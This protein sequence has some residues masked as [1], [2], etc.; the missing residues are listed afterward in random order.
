MEKC[1]IWTF[2]AVMNDIMNDINDKRKSLLHEK[3]W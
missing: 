3:S 1:E 2:Q